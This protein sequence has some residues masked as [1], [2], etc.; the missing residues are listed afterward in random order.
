[1]GLATSEELVQKTEE[2]EFE[3]RERRRH[4]A[5]WT[6][7]RVY[8]ISLAEKL[9]RLFMFEYSSVEV[10]INPAW[11]AGELMLE[12]KGDFN[13]YITSKSLQKQEGIIFRHLLRLI[14]LLGEF[15]ELEPENYDFVR[16]QTDL[17]EMIEGLTNCCIN[18]DPKSTKEFLS[19]IESPIT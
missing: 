16:W 5:G 11:A 12:F 18:V 4:F 3:E 2:E 6:E 7:E 9:L 14:L 8:V 13:K 1:M 17:T 15:K 10:R 19:K